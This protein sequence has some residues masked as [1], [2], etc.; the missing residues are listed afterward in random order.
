MVALLRERLGNGCA[1]SWTGADDENDFAGRHGL[2]VSVVG[3]TCEK[4]IWLRVTMDGIYVRF[5]PA[6]DTR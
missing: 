5:P 1:D 6:L 3:R 2:V 4:L